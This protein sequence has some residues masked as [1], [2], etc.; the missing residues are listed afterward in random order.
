MAASA[1]RRSWPSRSARLVEVGTTNR[2][3]VADY[4]RA[5]DDDTALLLK[6]HASNYRMVGFVETTPVDAL[7]RLGPP[8][9]VDAGS[10]LLDETT[11][12]LEQ[13]P[14]W[15]RDEPGVRQVIDGRRDARD[16]LG[17]QAARRPAGRDHRRAPRRSVATIARHPLRPRDARRQAHAGAA[18]VGGAPPTSSGDATEIPLW[19]MATTPVDDLRARAERL[20]GAMPGLKVVDTEAVAGGGSLPGLTIPSVGVAVVH[21]RSRRAPRPAARA[22]RRRPRRRR[23]ARVR[24]P[25]G[26]PRRRRPPAGSALARVVRVVATAGHVDH[27]KSTL[28]LALTGTDP[29]RF[30]E[31]KER[32]LTIDLGF[33]F[34]TLPSGREVG[35]VDVPGHVRFLKNMLAGVGAVDLVLL[36][37]AAHDGWMPQSEE[38]LRILELLGVRHGVVVLTKRRHRS[39]P[40]TLEHRAARDRRAAVAVVAPRR[41]RSSCATRCRVAASTTSAPRSTPRWDRRRPPPDA[42]RPRL[43]VDRVFAPRGAGTV[44]TGTL[45][46]GAVAVGDALEVG[47]DRRPR[48][49]ARDRDGASP[50]RP[51][52]ARDARRAE[53]RRRRALGARSAVTRSCGRASGPRRRS[54]TWPSPPRPASSSAAGPACRPTSGPVSTRCGARSSTMPATLARLRFLTPIP[55]AP[56]DRVVLRDAGRERTVAGAEV[57]DVEPSGTAHDTRPRLRLPL[58]ARL[59]ARARR[60]LVADIG[61]PHRPGRRRRPTR[62]PTSMVAS[63]SRCAPAAST[64]RP[65]VA[66]RRAAN[67]LASAVQATPG[68]DLATLAST[69][70]MDAGDLRAMRG[71]RRRS[72][73]SSAASCARVTQSP[74]DASPEAVALL[75]ALDASPFSP[76]DPSTVGADPA[77]VRCAR[78]PRRPRRHRRCRLHAVGRRPRRELVREHLAAHDTITV[79]DARDRFASSRKYVVPLLEH[80]DREGV[81]RRR[82]D[83]RIAGPTHDPNRRQQSASTPL[84]DASL[85]LAGSAVVGVEEAAA[86]GLVETAPDAVHLADPDARTRGTRVAPGT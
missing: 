38:H 43:W 25:Y 26:R 66:A 30:A 44:V 28:V 79:G 74:I 70:A 85:P 67:G 57:L 68:I 24:P 83:V 59:L 33:A 76:P 23:C 45:V 37:V 60:V 52:R 75:A 51:R 58:E 19:R 7:A 2:T 6:V 31:E 55:L 41:R 21:R 36:V 50:R 73:S 17:R 65:G 71:R 39:T 80:F 82:G 29:D 46:G 62:S 32:G 16:V 4:E 81:T 35:F 48:P 86:L 11:P 22:R 61:A 53:P 5:I 69:L 63:G 8:V 64:R 10:G 15:L 72:S 18:P 12:W 1:S 27:G 20:A 13:R 49:R 3:R 84:N 54:S 77:L 47:A 56:G 78:P 14:P 42:D 34:T 40:I 9:M